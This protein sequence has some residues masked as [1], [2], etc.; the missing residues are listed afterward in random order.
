MGAAHG[1]LARQF[2]A[3][4]Y[5]RIRHAVHRWLNARKF[6]NLYHD[7]RHSSVTAAELARRYHFATVAYLSTFCRKMSGRT[8]SDIRNLG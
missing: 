8:P 1:P 5:Q 7:L 4:L 6:D 3:R 2:Q